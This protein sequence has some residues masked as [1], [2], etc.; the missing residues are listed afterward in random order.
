[1]IEVQHLTRVFRTYKKQPGFWGGVLCAGIVVGLFGA[2]VE[3]LL[4]RRL[5]HAPE[6]LQLLATFALVLVFK[7]LDKLGARV[8]V[9][10]GVHIDD[11]TSE[12]TLSG[13]I[14]SGEGTEAPRFV[15]TVGR[16]LK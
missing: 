10:A 8:E 1:M 3:R 4:L 16:E 13:D 11:V 6:L 5:Y 7:D 14:G 15:I 12:G 2:L 9:P